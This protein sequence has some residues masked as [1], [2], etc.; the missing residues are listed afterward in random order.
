MN[1][2]YTDLL[3]KIIANTIYGS[4][5]QVIDPAQMGESTP[6]NREDRLQG[7]D[8]PTVAHSMAGIKR[9]S[10]VRDLVQRVIDENVPGDF[11]ETGV[12]RGGCC[13][14]MKGVLAAN[15]VTDRKVYVADSFDG[16]PQP[17]AENYPALA[18]VDTII[19]G[20]SKRVDVLQT[21]SLPRSRQT[22]AKRFALLQM[23]GS[24]CLRGSRRTSL[25]KGEGNHNQNFYSRRIAKLR[26]L[27]WAGS[28]ISIF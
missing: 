26:R 23:N 13:I 7:R 3:I 19:H 22:L 11:I 14:L 5:S 17:D 27:R 4:G 16:L 12:R 10:N 25:A 24:R 18:V 21:W 8:W 6:F 20:S 9:L 28:C 15:E 2:L 1:R